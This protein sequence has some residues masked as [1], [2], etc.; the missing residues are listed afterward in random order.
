M[1]LKLNQEVF[2]FSDFFRS[3]K[4]LANVDSG[5]FIRALGESN[6]TVFPLSITS[7]LSLLIMVFSLWAIVKTVA[8]SNSSAM[9]FWMVCSVTTSMFAVASSRTTILFLLRMALQ[10]QMSYLSPALRFAPFSVILK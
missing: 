7:T 4:Y 9:S 8:P 1:L 3:F 10:M 2:F 5:L 6:S